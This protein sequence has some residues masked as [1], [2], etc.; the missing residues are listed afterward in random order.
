MV[1]SVMEGVIYA[2]YSIGKLLMEK[3]PSIE[4]YATGGF[5]NSPLWLQILA[6]VSNCNVL[7]SGSAESSAMGAVVVGLESLNLPPLPANKI[8]SVHEPDS[9]RHE[10]YQA[11]FKKFERIYELLKDEFRN[12]SIPV[13]KDLPVSVVAL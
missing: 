7:V 11:Q 3:N 13:D 5:A 9:S 10:I 1:R 6:D 8:L 12:D 2:V 4:I